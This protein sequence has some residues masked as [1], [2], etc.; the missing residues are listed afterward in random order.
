MAMV[1][2]VE[3]DHSGIVIGRIVTVQIEPGFVE[4]VASPSPAHPASRLLEG[5]VMTG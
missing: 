1:D 4:I 5:L 3:L 2:N